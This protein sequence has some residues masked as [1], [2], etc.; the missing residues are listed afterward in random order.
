MTSRKK[1]KAGNS[2]QLAAR[3]KRVCL[4]YRER[5]HTHDSPFKN[6]HKET[7]ATTQESPL[8]MTV[9]TNEKQSFP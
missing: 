4:S 3:S 2:E 1:A 6:T 5:E 8:Q 7:K 9:K